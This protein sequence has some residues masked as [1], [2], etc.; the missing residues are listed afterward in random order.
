ME[1]LNGKSIVRWI[2][3]ILAVLSS[4]FIL[5]TLIAHGINDGFGPL[6]H[7][8]LRETLMMAAFGMIWIGLMIGWKWELAGGIL[9]LGGFFFFYV[10]DFLFSGTFPRGP[11]FFML[12]A[13]GIGYFYYGMVKRR[14]QE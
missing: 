1:G 6:P 13:P 14:S 11:I 7:L 5:I 4:L 10:L 3:R 2:S 8:T 12:A 9:V